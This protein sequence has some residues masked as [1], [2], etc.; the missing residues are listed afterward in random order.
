[1]FHHVAY[2]WRGFGQGSGVRDDH[3]RV[4][5]RGCQ[6]SIPLQCSSFQ[7]SIGS[8]SGY[9]PLENAYRSG[10]REREREREGRE[11]E[12]ER[13]RERGKRERERLTIY[14][15]A[16][17]AGMDGR[18]S[19]AGKTRDSTEVPP[20]LERERESERERERARPPRIIRS[21]PLR[22][23]HPR[24]YLRFFPEIPKFFVGAVF[25]IIPLT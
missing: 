2:L 19:R 21:G 13:E 15:H 1:L 7:K 14:S 11:R 4:L 16:S 5:E 24:E 17:S 23:P 18:P 10:D 8:V 25:G 12:R 22:V 6:K 3:R 9:S 20:A